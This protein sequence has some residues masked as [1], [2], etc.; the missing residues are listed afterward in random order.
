ML[1]GRF[2]QPP[3]ARVAEPKGAHALRQ[4]PFDAR[5]SGIELVPLFTGISGPGGVQGLI[6]CPWLE[7][8]RARL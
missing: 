2:R 1:Q 5:S 3:I 7:L 8:Q 4:G 6:V